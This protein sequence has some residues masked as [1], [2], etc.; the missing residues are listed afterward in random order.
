MQGPVEHIFLYILSNEINWGKIVLEV[1]N[2]KA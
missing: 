1:N 2:Y